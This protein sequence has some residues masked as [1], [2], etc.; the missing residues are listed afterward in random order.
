MESRLIKSDVVQSKDGVAHVLQNYTWL[1]ATQLTRRGSDLQ[2]AVIEMLGVTKHDV[3][4]GNQHAKQKLC[5]AFQDVLTEKKRLTAAGGQ[6][7]ISAASCAGIWW[8]MNRTTSLEH[9]PCQ[10]VAERADG[11]IRSLNIAHKV[12]KAL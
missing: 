2:A 5:E 4:Q 8:F 3:H 11:K 1:D 6:P 9:V 10:Q 12:R 7:T